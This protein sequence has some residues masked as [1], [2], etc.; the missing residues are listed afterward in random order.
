MTDGKITDQHRPKEKYD[1]DHMINAM[2]NSDREVISH[3]SDNVSSFDQACQQAKN[4]GVV[5]YTIAF[6]TNGDGVKQMRRCAT[7]PSFFFKASKSSISK[8][9][10]AI[11]AGINQLRLTQ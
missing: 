11:A 1:P 6:E 2:S 4:N 9:F 8:V 5:V 10:S 3:K 7:S